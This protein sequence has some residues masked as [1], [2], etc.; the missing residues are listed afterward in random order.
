MCH[1][2]DF[3]PSCSFGLHPWTPMEDFHHPNPCCTEP[4]HFPNHVSIYVTGTINCCSV[5]VD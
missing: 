5:C 4:Y 3:L 2:L 1:L